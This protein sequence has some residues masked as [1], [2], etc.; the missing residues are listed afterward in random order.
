LCA[1]ATSSPPI[2]DDGIPAQNIAS[3]YVSHHSFWFTASEHKIDLENGRYWVWNINWED[4]D[5]GEWP[6]PK[7]RDG[8]AENAGFD[9]VCD[10]SADKI[11]AF[12][13]EANEMGFTSWNEEYIDPL[14]MDGHQWYVEIT[15]LDGSVKRIV[16]SNDYPDTWDDMGE[17]FLNLTGVDGIL[18]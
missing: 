12:C 6:R 1:T 3:V 13:A 9:L 8:T 7:N 17:A 11:S 10:L 16:G 18:D 14:L 2:A 4:L 15:F 5:D